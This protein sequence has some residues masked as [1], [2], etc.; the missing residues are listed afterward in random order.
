MSGAVMYSAD[1]QE[2]S[3]LCVIQRSEAVPGKL[4]WATCALT[5][6]FSHSESLSRLD[7]RSSWFGISNVTLLHP[8]NFEKSVKFTKSTLLAPDKALLVLDNIQSSLKLKPRQAFI[9]AG[10]DMHRGCCNH[11]VGSHFDSCAH[12]QTT[13]HSATMAIRAP[14]HFTEN[15]KVSMQ[16]FTRDTATPDL[17]QILCTVRHPPQNGL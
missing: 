15:C 11:N 5:A 1:A 2:S 12:S 7:S 3:L 10:K 17:F 8:V 9:S 13:S 4:N 14:L 16:I 6:I